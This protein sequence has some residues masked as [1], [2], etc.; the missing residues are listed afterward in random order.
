[1]IRWVRLLVV[2]SPSVLTVVL[3][4]PALADCAP[5]DLACLSNDLG[6]TAGG[7]V[8]AGVDEAI[9]HASDTAAPV[10]SG[11]IGE[12]ERL[13]GGGGGPPPGGGDPAPDGNRGGGGK[14]GG[15]RP[16]GSAAAGPQVGSSSPSP[17]VFVATSADRDPTDRGSSLAD[18]VATAVTGAARS[19]A[20]VFVLLGVAVG[21]VLF[22]DR[23]DRRDPKLALAPVGPD[24]ISFA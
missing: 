16:A 24:A 23:L 14:G 2:I 3:G 13:T 22:Q 17:S 10:V 18:R 4:H 12:V 19:F 15:S 5:S 20:V 1:M 11:V 9:E 21:F 7:P 8:P 6:R